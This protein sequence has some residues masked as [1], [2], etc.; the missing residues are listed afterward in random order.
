VKENRFM[1]G[2]TLTGTRRRA[3]FSFALLIGFSCASYAASEEIPPLTPAQQQLLEGTLKREL[4]P[5]IKGKRVYEGQTQDIP[6]TISVFADKRIILEL[7]AE[8]G[9]HAEEELEDF[10]SG[11]FYQTLR[12]ADEYGE[13]AIIKFTYGGLPFEHYSSRERREQKSDGT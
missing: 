4:A 7:G 5:L 6:L 1:F 9:P 10:H 11:L 13:G 2:P 3:V 12:Y 8:A